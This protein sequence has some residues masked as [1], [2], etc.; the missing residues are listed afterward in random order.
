MYSEEK[1]TRPRNHGFGYGISGGVIMVV[2]HLMLLL[3]FRGANNGDLL[4]WFLS[5]FVYFMVG[6]M[7]AQAQFISQKYSTLPLRGV[8]SAGLGAG[9]VASLLIW[10]FIIVR[11]IFRD[12]VGIF[13]V[14]DPVGLFCAITVDIMIAMGLGRLGGKMVAD[15]YR[16][17]NV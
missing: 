17:S 14:V 8:E 13:I 11:G 4:A 1:T 16:V 5:W 6:R 10:G 15:K 9:L 3:I 7:A 2:V 12:A